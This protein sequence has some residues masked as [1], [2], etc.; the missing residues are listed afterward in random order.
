MLE[1]VRFVD[2]TIG[3][4]VDTFGGAGGEDKARAF[5]VYGYAF[6]ARRP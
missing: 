4:P 3:P 2:V 5:D 1:D 6:L